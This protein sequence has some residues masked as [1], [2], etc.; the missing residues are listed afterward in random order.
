MSHSY[1]S[2]LPA[3]SEF[4]SLCQSQVAL[5]TQ[6]LGAAWSV[7]YLTQELGEDAQTQ[8]IPVV[9]YPDERAF[10]QKI[11][12]FQLAPESLIKVNIHPQLTGSTTLGTTEKLLEQSEEQKLNSFGKEQALAGQLQIVIPLIHEGSMM[13]LLVTGREDRQWNERELAQINQIVKTMAIACHLDQSQLW[14]GRQLSLQIN[15]RERLDDLLHQLRNPLTA[16]RTFSK[17]LLKRL[18]GSP[19]DAKVVESII[20]ESDHLQELL[21]QFDLW[22]DSLDTQSFPLVIDTKAAKLPQTSSSLP[23]SSQSSPLNN[24]AVEV[25]LA[26]LVDSAVVVAQ[27]KK[28]EFSVDIPPY[29]PLVQANASALRE[30]IGNLLDNALKYTPANGKV[31]LQAGMEQQINNTVF[32]GIAISDNGVGIPLP[33]QTRIFERHYRGVQSQGNIPGTGL[34]LAIAQEL[35]EQMN[36]KIE[37]ISPTISNSQGTTFIVWLQVANH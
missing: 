14:Y 28:I 31:H 6:G 35:I 1:P 19:R 7:L 15:L 5:L 4:V 36:G 32:Q 13:G 37:L 30:I 33:D 11:G 23:P 8:L 29:L 10:K 26:P 34:G 21:Q 24:L 27:D 17:L 12:Q 20:R 2:L 18:M 9:V 22:M 16:L 25:I 3:S